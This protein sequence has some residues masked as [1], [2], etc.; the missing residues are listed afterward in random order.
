MRLIMS[1]AIMAVTFVPAFGGELSYATPP[2][3]RPG[4]SGDDINSLGNVMGLTQLRHIK[5]WFAGRQRNWPLARY[6]LDQIADTLRHAGMFYQNIPVDDVKAA[7]RQLD[8]I[9]KATDG[10]DP[11]GFAKGY[12]A[13]TE[14]CNACHKAAQVGF[15]AIRTPTASPFSDQG[16]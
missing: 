4:S 8:A 3:D 10:K 11:V 16:F 9:R 12:A 15:I 13:L 2:R 6:E 5:L 1:L 7:E 14:S